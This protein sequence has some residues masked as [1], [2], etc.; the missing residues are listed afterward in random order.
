MNDTIDARRRAL[1]KTAAAGAGAALLASAATADEGAKAASAVAVP[2]P[3]KPGD[4]DFLSGEW[5]IHHRRLKT[6]DTQDW[7]EFDGEATCWSILG[8]A[9]SIEELR[10]PARNFSG[11]GLRVLDVEK[12]VW[13]DFWVNA[14]TGVIAAPGVTGHFINGAGIFES[15]ELDGGKPLKVR[16][17]WDRITPRSCRWYQESSRDGGKTWELNWEM[18]WTRA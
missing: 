13:S 17:V 11:M 5:K 12:K 18:A 2:P 7:D 6:P 16:G 14:R 15:D 9:V 1:L 10:I 4:F 3:G 8:G